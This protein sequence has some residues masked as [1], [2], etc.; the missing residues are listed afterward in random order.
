MSTTDSEIMKQRKLG[1]WVVVG[2]DNFSYEYFLRSTHDTE[3]EARAA[4]PRVVPNGIDTT[5]F[6]EG[7]LGGGENG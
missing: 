7:P 4:C 6:V 2:S 3:A 1:K 5:Y